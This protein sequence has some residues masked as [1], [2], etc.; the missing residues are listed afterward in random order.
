MCSSSPNPIAIFTNISCVVG[1][2]RQR[3]HKN[4]L[5]H[6]DAR[7]L[8]EVQV[9]HALLHHQY[10]GDHYHGL[11]TFHSVVMEHSEF[12]CDLSFC[13]AG[14]MSSFGAHH[15]QSWFDGIFVVKSWTYTMALDMDW[16]GMAW[17]PMNRCYT[18]GV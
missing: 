12:Q 11:R 3:S 9:E 6:R 2:N 5:L 13:I 17:S 16:N 18:H 8:Q 4:K 7:R 1:S 15:S 10:R 14:G